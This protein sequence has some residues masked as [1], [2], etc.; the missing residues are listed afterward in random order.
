M[1]HDKC[2]VV[3]HSD[4][5]IDFF[6]GYQARADDPA[7]NLRH[8]ELPDT[9]QCLSGS[10]HQHVAGSVYLMQARRAQVAIEAPPLAEICA[11]R[12]KELD[13]CSRAFRILESAGHTRVR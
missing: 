5:L 2:F 11:T 9:G 8:R 10:D 7:A 6:L 12:A 1:H 4:P 3:M 13:Q